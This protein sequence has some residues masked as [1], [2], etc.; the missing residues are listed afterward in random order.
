MLQWTNTRL[1]WDDLKELVRRGHE[2]ALH[3][4]SHA[5]LAK[6]VRERKFDDLRREIVFGRDEM[7]RNMGIRP[8]LFVAPYSCVTPEAVKIIEDAGMTLLPVS[9]RNFGYDTPAG[10]KDGVGAYLDAKAASGAEYCD[11]MVHGVGAKSGGWHPFRDVASYERH[12]DEIAARPWVKVVVGDEARKAYPQSRLS[13]CV[14]VDDR[15]LHRDW[16]EKKLP[17]KETETE[18]ESV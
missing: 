11:V 1:D 10:T 6:L 4:Y 5:N 9:R 15:E 8:K 17:E 7:E 18:T 14:C 16:Y 2:V 13:E 3:G 12:L